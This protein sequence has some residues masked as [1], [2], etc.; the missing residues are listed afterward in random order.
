MTLK[1]RIL[2]IAFLLFVLGIIIHMVKKRVLELKYV[3]IWMGC[4][5]ALIILAIFPQLMNGLAELLGIYLP[6]NMIFFLG[7]LF[8]LIIIF[9]LTVTLSKVTEQVRRIAQSLAMLPEEVRED[10]LNQKNG[11]DI[12]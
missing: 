10:I 11:G 5:L 8:S 4:D 1:A 6:V 12:S 3:L 9:S 7:F 2:L